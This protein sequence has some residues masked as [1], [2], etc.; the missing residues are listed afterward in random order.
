MGLLKHVEA[1]A[2][3]PQPAK[4][5]QRDCQALLAQLQD[6]SVEQRRWAARDLPD[7]V[8]NEQR[9]A[10]AQ[11]LV[12]HLGSEPDRSVREVILTSLVMLH[13]VGSVEGLSECL[14]S[15]DIALRNQAIEAMTM[16]PS[17]AAGCMQGLLSD[18]SSDMRMQA[19]RVL[20]TYDQPE[21]SCWLAQALEVEAHANVC[22]ALIDALNRVGRADALA[23][24]QT[25]KTRFIGEPY[26]Q[27]AADVAIKRI[28]ES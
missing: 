15:P 9:A 17:L 1:Q 26:L 24:L 13:D 2:R 20:E 8:S 6:P 12:R 11:A 16:M 10:V 4:A 23:A 7:C 28:R 5:G 18:P 27:F 14:R 22:G 3:T 21:A 19:A 25:A